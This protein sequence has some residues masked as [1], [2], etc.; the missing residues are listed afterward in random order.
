MSRRMWNCLLLM[1][2]IALTFVFPILSLPV[3]F[4]GIIFSR[5]KARKVYAFLIAISLALLAYVWIPDQS[6]D[7]FR[8][9]NDLLLLSNSNTTQLSYFIQ[10]DFEPAHYLISYVIA[11]IGNMNLLQFM[12]VLCGYFELLWIICDFAELKKVKNSTFVL[13]LLYVFSAVKFIGFAS[14]LWCNFAII[15]LALGAYLQFFRNTR[16]FHYV[17][18]IAAALLHTGTIY[19]VVLVFIFG[20]MKIF[21][22][23]RFSTLAILFAVVLSFGGIVMF[24]NNLL[25]AESGIVSIINRLYNGYFVN[26][27]QFESLHTGWNLYLPVFNILFGLALLIKKFDDDLKNR[28]RSLVIY[29]SVCLLATIINAGIFVRYGFLI[30]IMLMPIIYEFIEGERKSKRVLPIVIGIIIVVS[31]LQFYRSFA[32]MESAGLITEIKKD[33]T[34][35]S[36]ELLESHNSGGSI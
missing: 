15:N 23:T 36:I 29:T 18:H 11:Q 6:M 25:G 32:Q 17:C 28:Y 19:M 24:L 1:F 35:S 30:S 13:L 4:I 2:A 12:V 9:H 3:S 7:L 22:R 26:G 20:K 33:I 27:D 31:S 34:T 14:G 21:R 10:Q 16:Y 8:H 5:G